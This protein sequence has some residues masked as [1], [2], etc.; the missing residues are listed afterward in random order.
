[1]NASGRLTPRQAAERTGMSVRWLHEQVR[2]GR[3][4]AFGGPRSRRFQPDL[5][6]RELAELARG[7]PAAPEA[8]ASDDDDDFDIPPCNDW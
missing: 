6:D 5:L 1:M 2:L 8:T 3:I 7:L 4:T